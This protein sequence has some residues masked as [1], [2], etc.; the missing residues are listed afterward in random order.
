LTALNLFE[1]ISTGSSLNPDT[2]NE[3]N[4]IICEFNQDF[5]IGDEI[6]ED[7]EEEFGDEMYNGDQNEEEINNNEVEMRDD[8]NIYDES[9]RMKNQNVLNKEK[10][11]PYNFTNSVDLIFRTEKKN[12]RELSDTDPRRFEDPDF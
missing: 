1:Q 2:F 11:Q 4:N 12:R 8:N 6:N 7:E 9:Q 10:L 5:Y 3:D